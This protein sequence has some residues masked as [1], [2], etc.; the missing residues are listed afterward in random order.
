MHRKPAFH[1]SPSRWKCCRDRT[2]EGRPVSVQGC[3]GW[4]REI[5]LNL[6]LNTRVYL[7]LQIHH[8]HWSRGLLLFYS[9]RVSDWLGS[10]APRPHPCLHLGTGSD[11]VL[12]LGLAASPKAGFPE[13]R[14]GDHWTLVM[15]ELT[16]A[17]VFGKSL[18]DRQR[19]QR[20]IWKGRIQTLLDF[21][22]I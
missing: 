10:C 2:C 12:G 8:Q 1:S 13:I 7:Y 22:P 5:C 15:F 20:V 21:C 6:R 17:L 9:Q 4:G 19:W 14:V 3:L 18:L 11:P 16:F